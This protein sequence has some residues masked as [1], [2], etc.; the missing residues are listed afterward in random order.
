MLMLE[1]NERVLEVGPGTGFYTR[2]VAG[3]LWSGG[4]LQ[5]LDIQEQML[6]HTMQGS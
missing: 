2:H 5:I 4:T 6:E 3:R 1:G